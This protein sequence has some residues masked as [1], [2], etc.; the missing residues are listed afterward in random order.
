MP[1]LVFKMPKLAF[2]FYEMDPTS[3]RNESKRLPPKKIGLKVL[4]GQDEVA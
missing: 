4:Y 1:K 2:K 3:P